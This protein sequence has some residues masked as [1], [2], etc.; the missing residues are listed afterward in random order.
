MELNLAL[1]ENYYLQ[2]V[3]LDFDRFSKR[4]LKP[5]STAEIIKAKHDKKP[6]TISGR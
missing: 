1:C 4:L 6:F 2:I 3:F 5:R